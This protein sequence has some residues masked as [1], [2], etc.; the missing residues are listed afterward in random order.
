MLRLLALLAPALAGAAP[1]TADTAFGALRGSSLWPQGCDQW[2][3]IPYAKAP[4]GERRFR[5]P[6]P[7]NEAYPEQGREAT[8][9]GAFCPQLFGGQEDCLFLNVWRPTRT[10]AGQDLPVMAWIHGGAFVM[11][12]ASGGVPGPVE[13]MFNVYE[14][15]GLAARHGV[16]VAS[17][18][19]RLGPLGFAAF[20]DSDGVHANFGIKDQRE[21]LAWLQKAL[22]AFG[23]DPAKVTIF[24]ES[25]GAIS[26]FHHVASPLSSG[27]F[28]AAISESGMPMAWSTGFSLEVTQR[29]AAR[30]G[31]AEAL[32][33]R[34]CLGSKDARALIAVAGEASNPFSSVG[35]SP[36]VD[37]A[38]MPDEPLQLL[39]EGR[40]AAVPLLAGTNTDEAN[41]FVWPYFESGMSEEQYTRFLHNFLD[42]HDP[43]TRLN[44]TEEA[45]VRRLYSRA[46]ADR[47]AELSAIMTDATFLC[48]TQ[49]AGQAQGSRADVFL[50]RFNHRSSCE[51][52]LRKSVPGVFHA[53]EL[54]YVFGD[55]MKEL[56]FLDSAERA[57]SARIQ[58]LWT[59]FAKSLVPVGSKGAAFPRYSN[60]SRVGVVL[61]TPSDELE[62]GYRAEY[63]GFW[64]EVKSHKLRRPAKGAGGPEAALFV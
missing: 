42:G 63:C 37:G 12:A 9:Y 10:R 28:R 17:M 50:Y 4:V 33:L 19:Y 57:L 53:S 25:A 5:N 27:L 1:V 22:P 51:R 14:G 8:A 7:W 44:A 41:L 3:G 58:A 62:E 24:G 13:D 26:V 16:V 46:G 18:N 35:W 36:A 21:A 2:L 39:L 55:P 61:Q 43:A 29:F 32:S 23:G 56:C 15:C 64:R 52:I 45:M 60:A 11:G 34:D 59:S 31:C 48:G 38:D 30:L 40:A 54:I 20:N 47:R 6:E 49:D